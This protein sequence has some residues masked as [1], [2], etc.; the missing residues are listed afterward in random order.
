MSRAWSLL[1]VGLVPLGCKKDPAPDSEATA[2]A[3]TPRIVLS[4]QPW[5]K[6]GKT[7]REATSALAQGGD[8]KTDLHAARGKAQGKKYKPEADGRC[9]TDEKCRFS[10][11]SSLCAAWIGETAKDES[12]DVKNVIY[13]GCIAGCAVPPDAGK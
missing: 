5:H 6:A 4:Q 7:P 9:K 2:S 12:A 3:R 13:L 8:V 10:T 1:L 11:C